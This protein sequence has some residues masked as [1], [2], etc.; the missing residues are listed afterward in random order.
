M[1][2]FT[3]YWMDFGDPK[4]SYQNEIRT[5]TTIHKHA[6]TIEANQHNLNFRKIVLLVY[7]FLTRKQLNHV[8]ESTNRSLLFR[9]CRRFKLAVLIL[10]IVALC[11]LWLFSLLFCCFF[12]SISNWVIL[13]DRN[14]NNGVVLTAFLSLSPCFLSNCHTQLVWFMDRI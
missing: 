10:F 2:H 11:L 12:F 7:W 9:W 8:I 14:V 4:T 1:F 13:G 6:H 3:L 5:T